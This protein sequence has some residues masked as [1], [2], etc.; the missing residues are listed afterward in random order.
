MSRGGV[1][2]L[3]RRPDPYRY[4]PDRLDPAVIEHL[5]TL[6]AD[7]VAVD[8]V[9]SLVS[10]SRASYTVTETAELLS[11]S[12][13]HLYARVKSTGEIA[14]GLGVIRSG[15]RLMIAAHELRR[16]LRLPDPHLPAPAPVSTWTLDDLSPEV[17]A[18]IVRL[19]VRTLLIRLDVAGA[20]SLPPP[21]VFSDE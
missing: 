7:P 10:G 21:E 1:G 19:T 13:K 5:A 11:V 20:I 16:F 15:D 17:F 9:A 12:A 8:L 6:T 2:L 4:G 14:P 18:A 3:A